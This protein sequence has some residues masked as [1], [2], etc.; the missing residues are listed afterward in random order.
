VISRLNLSDVTTVQQMVRRSAAALWVTLGEMGK[1]GQE[2]VYPTA[3][4]LAV[5]LQRSEATVHRARRELESAGLVAIERRP[6]GPRRSRS[7]LW[8]VVRPSM[9]QMR[10]A[11]VRVAAQR[12]DYL[13]R[14]GVIFASHNPTQYLVRPNNASRNACKN[15]PLT[16]WLVREGLRKAREGPP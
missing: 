10:E 4:Y 6:C 2:R 15:S 3:A 1:G 8:R 9:A 13:R 11:I 5:R 12:Q 16:Q 7:N 14:M